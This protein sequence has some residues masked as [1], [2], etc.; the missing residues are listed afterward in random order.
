M[1]RHSTGLSRVTWILGGIALGAAAMY[2][3]DPVQGNRRR[4]LVRDKAYSSRIRLRK[5]INAKSRDLANRAKGLRAE[6]R[7][8]LE[9]KERDA[10]AQRTSPPVTSAEASMIEI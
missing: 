6:A 5:T 1:E 9:K 7:H 10:D 4:A 3:M 2:M 8:M